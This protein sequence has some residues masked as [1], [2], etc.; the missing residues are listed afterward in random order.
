MKEIMPK[1]KGHESKKRE[2]PKKDELSKNARTK[3]MPKK[4]AMKKRTIKLTKKR[5]PRHR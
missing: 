1:G 5:K 4:D 2:A 3:T